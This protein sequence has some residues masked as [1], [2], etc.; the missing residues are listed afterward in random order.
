MSLSANAFAPWHGVFETVR[1][2]EGLPLFL[3]EH[4]A[5]WGE[6]AAALGLTLSAD[7]V[8]ESKKLPRLSGR[9]RWILRREGAEFLFTEEKFE[10]P[11]PIDLSLSPLRLGSKNWDA[12]FKTLSYLTHSQAREQAA[13]PEVVLL[14]EQGQVA[15]AASSNLFWVKA[16]QLFTPAHEAGC[17]RGI[18]RNFILQKHTTIEGYFSPIVLAEADELFLTNS[19]RGIVSVR[20]WEKTVWNTFPFADRLRAEYAA[21]IQRQ[22][23]LGRS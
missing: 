3:P 2:I 11:A 15:S 21:E 4:R 5:A 18:V 16:G 8:A 1:V 10:S 6:G 7:V 20:R 23:E 19:L 14:N 22:L 9:W 13:T 12:R 17:R